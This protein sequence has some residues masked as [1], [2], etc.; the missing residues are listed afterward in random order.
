MRN[1]RHNLR[2][3]NADSCLGSCD[4][5]E[6]QHAY[7]LALTGLIAVSAISLVAKVFYRAKKPQTDSDAKC[8]KP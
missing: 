5:S 2:D 3:V 1:E 8:T 6:F 7:I 4:R